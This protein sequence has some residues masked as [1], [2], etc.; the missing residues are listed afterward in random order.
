MV[1]LLFSC[2]LSCRVKELLIRCIGSARLFYLNLDK[3]LFFFFF[4]C[5]SMFR[6]ISSRNIVILTVQNC[7]LSLFHINIFSVIFSKT[8]LLPPQRCSL[9]FTCP[10]ECQ[11]HGGHLGQ[12]T[13]VF[14]FGLQRLSRSAKQSGPWRSH[15]TSSTLTVK[16]PE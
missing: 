9:A 4:Q 2:F 11:C 3:L 5:S 15:S 13:S 16:P 8:Q 7:K 10:T 12:A 6:E 14:T 1:T